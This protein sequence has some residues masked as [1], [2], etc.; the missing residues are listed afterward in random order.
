MKILI[1]GTDKGHVRE[2]NQD[3]FETVRL[4]PSLVFAI[5]C[6]G[7]GGENGGNIASQMAAQHIRQALQRDLKEDMHEQSIRSI[8]YSAVTGANRLIYDQAQST[9]ELSGMGTTLLAAVFSHRV[10]YAA[11][12]GDSRLYCVTGEKE[13]QLS[14]DHTVV[15]MLLDSGEIQPEE[16][17]SHPQRHYITRAVGVASVVDIDFFVRPIGEQE[18]VLLCSDGLYHYLVP[19]SF[20]DWVDRCVQQESVQPLIDFALAAGGADNITAVIAK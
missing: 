13:E 4:G 6:D 11:C 19:G 7:M 18:S 20:Y 14:K 12:V 15:Q 9:P 17:S 1:G 2:T 10:L 8:L 5:L 16:V 3:C